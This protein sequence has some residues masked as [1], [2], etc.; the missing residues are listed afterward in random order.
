VVAAAMLTGYVALEMADLGGEFG[1]DPRWYSRWTQQAEARAKA[2]P[3][4]GL[5]LSAGLILGMAPA[6]RPATPSRGRWR[7]WSWVVL[8]VPALLLFAL[9]MIPI[10]YLVLLALEAVSNAQIH[11]RIS[12]PGVW[13]RI[14]RAAPA[15][16]IAAAVCL[17]AG[18]WLSRELR[19]VPEPGA[20]PRRGWP[21]FLAAAGPAVAG[22]YLLFATIP[23]L[24]EWLAA[25]IGMAADAPVAAALVAGFAALAAGLAARAVAGRADWEPEAPGGAMPR[26]ARW[27]GRAGLFV[28]R[29][30]LI[31]LATLMFLEDSFLPFSRGLDWLPAPW[32]EH[33]ADARV[34]V[35][36]LPGADVWLY[37]FHPEPLLLELGLLWVAVQVAGLLS[38]RGPAPFDLIVARPRVVP[39]FVGAW[40]ALTAL[41]LAALPTLFVGG[42]VAF[43]YLLGPWQAVG[44]R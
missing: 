13:A 21:L 40:L 14:D 41:C 30:V 34:W 29:L 42:I 15:A 16:S 22:A 5:F 44:F 31:V 39:R 19:R 6:A 4:C 7:G 25:G 8:S 27:L 2:L 36:G 3:L 9:A 23:M 35:K 33:F 10:A 43:H 24:H 20:K 28:A 38:T 18:V 37:A 26:A 1:P 11:V 12:R 17:G 32:S